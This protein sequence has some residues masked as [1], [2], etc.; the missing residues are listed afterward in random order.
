MI[1]PRK[2]SL[3]LSVLLLSIFT[4][5]SLTIH[6]QGGK[7]YDKKSDP[8]VNRRDGLAML[9]AVNDIVRRYYFDPEFRGLDLTAK[10]K[11]AEEQI[12][13]QEFRWQIHRTIAQFLLDLNDSHT[14][15]Y[16]PDR[17]FR[18]EYGFSMM[19]IGEHCFVTDI[20][21]KS[22][23]ARTGLS[24]GDRIEGIN[25][26]APNRN[27]FW[28]INYLI[29]TLD[30]Q[31]TL[32]LDIV[33]PNGEKAT[34]NI[35]TRF[36]SPAERKAERQKRK[37]EEESKP[38]TCQALSDEVV[39]CKL[40][41]FVVAKDIVDKMMKE[42]GNSKKLVLDL[43]GNGGG[44]V[45][46]LMHMLG[47][48][49]DRRVKVGT[50]VRR[51]EKKE[52]YADPRGA[53]F[54]GDLFVLVDSQSASASEVFSRTIQIEKR[55][56]VIGD[57]SMGAVMTSGGIVISLDAGTASIDFVA[58][59]NF[60]VNITIADLVMS[61]GGRLEGT[62]VTP[63]H[64]VGPTTLALSMRNDPILA[65][66]ASLAG[67]TITPENAGKL[68]FFLPKAEEESDKETENSVD[69]L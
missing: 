69:N 17:L 4:S 11:A 9:K 16:P 26:L 59:R 66:A 43:R 45:D 65:F 52:R 68:N 50:E 64:L 58:T 28:A 21:Q 36:L 24:A 10:Y 63:D 44:Y 31:E 7:E 14:I 33:K 60:A 53:R 13:Q 35:K 5:T 62:G 55:G 40:R 67:V 23:A 8:K 54:G 29:Y 19:I 22:D 34:V 41:T 18:A 51:N 37:K 30:P 49:F 6:A 25:G 56:K 20:K 27:N 61:D 39:A 32:S 1:C 2:Y 38:Y 57:T 42:A 3:V 15:F 12:K 46:T 48:F 47:Y